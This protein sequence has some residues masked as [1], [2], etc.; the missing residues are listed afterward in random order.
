MK[1][2]LVYLIFAI[3]A[4]INFSCDETATGPNEIGG[5]TDVEFTKVGDETLASIYFNGQYVNN[6]KDSIVVIK[7]DNGIITT[8]AKFVFDTSATKA[9]DELLGT[10]GLTNEV[11]FNILNTYLNK[12][13]VTLDTTNKNEMSLTMALKSKVTSEGIQDFMYSGGDLSKPFT[14]VKYASQVGD[15]YEFTDV[16]NVKITRTVVSKSTTDDYP[17]AFWNIKVSQVEETKEDPIVEKITYIANHKFG[18]V[19]AVIKFKN[20]NSAKIGFIPPNM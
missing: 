7:N 10:N 19:G 15:K 13:G 20:G 1:K 3:F 17:V 6:V 5:S 4:V 2:H 16:D 14:I 8:F 18:M 12:F 9:L 11:K